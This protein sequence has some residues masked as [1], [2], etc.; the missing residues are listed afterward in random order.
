MCYLVVNRNSFQN[1]LRN[2]QKSIDLYNCGQCPTCQTPFDG[3][4]FVSL[5]ETLIEKKK[6]SEAIKLEIETNVAA[7]RE[8]QKKFY[9]GIV[10]SIRLCLCLMNYRI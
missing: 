10:L 6:S 2:I 7:L 4:H 9:W 3:E 1:E 5:L 8:K